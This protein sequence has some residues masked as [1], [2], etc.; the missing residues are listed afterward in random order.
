[1]HWS[2]IHK[3]VSKQC[4]EAERAVVRKWVNQN[5]DHQIFIESVEKIWSVSPREASEIN[6]REAWRQFHANKMEPLNRP[7]LVGIKQPDTS[8]DLEYGFK[9]IRTKRKLFYAAAAM[10]AL[11]IAV[12]YVYNVQLKPAPVTYQTI[13]TARGE[14]AQITLNDGTKVK[15]NAGTTLKIP[16]NYG[17]DSRK[18]LLEGE[19]FFSVKHDDALRFVV[20]T[21][22]KT[23]RDL[24]TA[25][26]IEAYRGQNLQVA[27]TEGKVA[28]SPAE[29]KTTIIRQPLILTKDEWASFE[30]QGNFLQR[31][32]GN[33]WAKVAWKEGV[34]VFDD[35][36]FEEAAKILERWYGVS[37]ILVDNA[38]KD[39]ILKGEHAGTSLE[40]VLESIDF[41]AGIEYSIKN[42]V[43]TIKKDEDR[44]N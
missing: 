6:V 26:N 24:G 38:L 29:V 31:G 2:L 44:T 43:V 23:I 7:H 27:V 13:A 1:M 21:R 28:V 9:K 10:A 22:H 39:I 42:G 18:V 35:T 20:Q 37:V 4:T 12:V 8:R 32:E 33:I 40:G 34:L 36:T 41:I 3:Y 5:P 11:F 17:I 19:A 25:F 30:P 15:L 14:R 16:S